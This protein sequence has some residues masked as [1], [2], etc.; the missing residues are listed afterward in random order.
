M[1]AFP[2]GAESAVIRFGP[3]RLHRTQGLQHGDNEVRITPKSLCVLWELASQAGQ[4]V[5]KQQLFRSVWADTAVSD[6]ALTT[7]IQELRQALHDDPRRPQYIETLHRRGYRFVYRAPAL[8]AEERAAIT[9]NPQIVPRNGVIA[10]IL[11]LW[12]AAERGARQLLFLGGEAGIGKT[13][14][15]RQ[16][17]ATVTATGRATASWGQCLQHY[18]IGEPYQPLLEALM[19]LCR[20]PGGSALVPVLEKY[21]PTWLAQ[22]PAL[23]PAERYEVLRRTAAGTTRRRMLRELTDAF[24]VAATDRPLALCLEDL[25]WSDASTLDWIAAFAQRPEPARVLLIGTFRPQADGSGG[26]P[27]S[28]VVEELHLK[29]CCREITLGGMTES[30]VADFAALRLPAAP[31]NAQD[32]RR[33]AMLVHRHTGGNPLFVLNVLDHLVARSLIVEQNGRW[34]LGAD[35]DEVDLGIPDDVRRIIAAQLERLRASECT[36]LEVASVAGRMFSAA[37]VAGAA[38]LATNDVESML[39]GLARQQRFVRQAGPRFEFDHDLY[40]DVLYERVPS[41]RRALLHREVAEREEESYGEGAGEIAA[42]LAMHFERSGDIRRAGM[43]LQQAAENAQSRN[44]CTE[45]RMH[46]QKAL[47]LLQ[48]EPACRERTE[49]EIN[50]WI[51]LGAAAMAARGWGT[52]DAERAFSRA[53]ELCSQLDETPS[54]FP[55]VWGLW[56]FY[57]GRGP[58]QTAHELAQDLLRLAQ[59]HTEDARLLQANHAA[60]ATA[61]SRGDLGAVCFHAGEGIRLYEP[62]RHAAISATYGSHDPGVCARL[63]LARALALMGRSEEAVRASDEALELARTLQHPF[64]LAVSHVFAAAVAHAC[65]QPDR[66]QAHAEAAASISRAQDFRLLIAWATVFEA[67]AA[68]ATGNCADALS[69]IE[70]AIAEARAMGSEQF[71]PHLAGVAA[72]AYLMTGNAVD[73]L[74]SVEEGLQVGQR[75]GERFWQPELL[76]L[77]GELQIAQNPR[78]TAEAE[79]AFRQAIEDAQSE[80]AMLLALRATVSLGR[81]LRSSGRGSEARTLL[82]EIL[83]GLDQCAGPDISEAN[84]LLCQLETR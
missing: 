25:H 49:R 67:W 24:E 21:A 34:V 31:R 80:G 40:R 18:G 11:N 59:S 47:S 7:C 57:W 78:A 53:R 83:H 61:F 63:F 5:T 20:Q 22:L 2:S 9:T 42:E 32:L 54:L 27:L 6:S 39:T 19:R 14:I 38:A 15:A 71:Q 64:S 72:E 50:L 55:A 56:L 66:V 65:R 28:K 35:L 43:Y 17:L 23:L 51:G 62:H 1:T 13:T 75:T 46:F 37:T 30:E 69:R 76:R 60:W 81:L 33:L 36:M 52:R 74:R 41:A 10:E 70:N 79:Q 68:V 8:P 58:L 16:V 77:R 3:F 29:R 44:A 4:I 84:T 48:N 82:F 45:A 73:G 26:H 12:S